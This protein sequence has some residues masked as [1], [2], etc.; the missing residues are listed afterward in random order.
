MRAEVPSRTDPGYIMLALPILASS[1]APPLTS[2]SNPSGA[3]ACSRNNPKKKKKTQARPLR[4]GRLHASQLH[5]LGLQVPQEFARLLPWRCDLWQQHP[6]LLLGHGISL[7]MASLDCFRSRWLQLAFGFRSQ[8]FCAQIQ[9]QD[10]PYR[11]RIQF[12]P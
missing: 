3:S 10:L 8:D 2:I 12:L 5:G 11:A 6:R 1:L 9:L 4:E 7:A